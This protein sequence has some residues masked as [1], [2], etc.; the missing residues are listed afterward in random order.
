M[1]VTTPIPGQNC[2][3]NLSASSILDK[4]LITTPSLVSINQE[5]KWIFLLHTYGFACLF[6]VLAFYTFL[7]ILHLRYIHI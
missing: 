6:F 5:L 7:S 4:L 1:N 2:V 3:S